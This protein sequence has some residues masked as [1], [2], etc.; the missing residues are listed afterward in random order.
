[1]LRVAVIDCQ[2]CTAVI[3]LSQVLSVGKTRIRSVLPVHQTVSPV[4]ADK[5]PVTSAGCVK[6]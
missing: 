2:T 6:V 4:P 5:R 1:M 3:C